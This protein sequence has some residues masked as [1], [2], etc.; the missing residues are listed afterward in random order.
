MYSPAAEAKVEPSEYRLA[1]VKVS[2]TI[3]VIYLM[4]PAK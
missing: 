4:S 1:P 2:Q 3:H